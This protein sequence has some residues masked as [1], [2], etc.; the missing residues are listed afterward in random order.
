MNVMR[1]KKVILRRFA[2]CLPS[3]LLPDIDDGFSFIET[4]LPFPLL[5]LRLERGLTGTVIEDAV[6][7]PVSFW[8]V[9]FV[10]G[11]F[12]GAIDVSG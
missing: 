9:R 1:S 3:L 6:H 5:F 12:G 11:G 2:D 4:P 7:E 10:S 8:S